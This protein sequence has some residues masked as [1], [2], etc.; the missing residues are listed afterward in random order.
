MKGFGLRSDHYLKALVVVFTVYVAVFVYLELETVKKENLLQGEERYEVQLEEMNPEEKEAIRQEVNT[1][2]GVLRNISRD[3]AD[4]RERSTE[5]WSQDAARSGSADP[6]QSAH[7]FEQQ[8]FD[9]AGGAAVRAR[10]QSESQERIRQMKQTGSSTSQS[11]QGSNTGSNQQYA[12][13]VMVDFS[14]PGRG[15]FEDNKWYVR[16]PGYTCGFNSAGLV[17]ID[18]QVNASG[19]VQSKTYNASKSRNAS[20]CMI[21]QALRY[22]GMSRFNPAGGNAS[23]YIEYRFVSQ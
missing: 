12:G 1:Q 17:H 6:V 15:A 11:T 4:T 14:V 18:I 5:N 13:E 3:A 10:I 8:V 19:R 2:T 7:D 23:G 16:N 21:E 9:E 20:A 22:A